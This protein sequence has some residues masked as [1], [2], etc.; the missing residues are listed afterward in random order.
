MGNHIGSSIYISTTL[1][2]TNDAAGFEALTWTEVNGLV[3][4]PQ[5]GFTHSMIDIPDLKTGKD[6]AVKGAGRGVDTQMM[7]REVASDTGQTSLKTQGD[8]EDGVLAIKIGEGSGTGAALTT[9]D[10][11][12]Y[13]QGIVHSYLPNQG[14]STS[15]EGFSVSFRQNEVTVVATEPA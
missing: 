12:Q 5:L 8:D 3:Q 4:L 13:A 6:S 7:F 14:N 10:P 11:V 9:G 1:P 2:A 15:Y